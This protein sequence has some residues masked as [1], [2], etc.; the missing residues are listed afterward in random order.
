MFA[1][2]SEDVVVTGCFT[3]GTEI[4]ILVVSCYSDSGISV[5]QDAC[6]LE[7]ELCESEKKLF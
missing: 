6:V 4:T 1:F 3:Y 2:S 5:L 7:K